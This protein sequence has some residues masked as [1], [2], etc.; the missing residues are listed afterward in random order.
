[1]PLED[2]LRA[3]NALNLGHYAEAATL[4]ERATAANPLL[5]DGYIIEGRALSNQGDDD[6][7]LA[8]LRKAVFLDPSAAHAHFL[9]AT[10]L[11]R[12]GDPNGAALSF[13]SAAETLPM[14]SP[15][16][17]SEL[18]D[19]RA[20]SDLVD[21]CRQLAVSLQPEARASESSVSAGSVPG[22]DGWRKP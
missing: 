6:G 9:L 17:L 5:V 15:E 21:L 1:L 13:A 19:G 10:T 11:A 7:A 3:R 16:T 22:D 8:A 12:V 2:V 14:A 4:A 20:V 18:L